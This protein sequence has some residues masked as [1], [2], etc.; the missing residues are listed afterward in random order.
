MK[1]TKLQPVTQI[2]RDLQPEDTV[3][4]LVALANKSGY[5]EKAD[6]HADF[7]RQL[8]VVADAFGR[9]L[10]EAECSVSFREAA[11]F[12][13][14]AREHR[15]PSTVADLRSYINRMTDDK[16][17]SSKSLRSISIADCRSLLFRKFGHSMHT[18]RK[19][20]S[21]LH[22]IFSY[23]MRQRWCEFNPAKAILRPPVT[24]HRIDI[25][26]IRQIR[27]MLECCREDKRLHPMEAPLRLMLWC[28]VRPTEMRRLCWND[29]DPTEAVVY[30]EPENSKTGGARAVPLRG[31][32]LRLL[33]THHTAE[34]KIAPSNWIR[35]WHALR[36]NAGFPLW[37]NDAL[38][39]TFASMHLKHFHN[40]PLLQEEMGH[41]NS[42][43]L[44]TR[45]LNL[46]N[47]RQ[48]TA[49]R[50]FN[51]DEWV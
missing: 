51:P 40:L 35:L 47:L 31:G 11:H 2:H 10:Q 18:Y 26:N 48:S 21:V 39:H 50:F 22:S 24:E 28:G 38:R 6:S 7:L 30:V 20:Q 32:A 37:Q 23:G 15:R 33:H 41:R 45:Y 25:L 4:L 44:Q 49:R 3:H 43:L 42:H 34:E 13:M 29:V 17:I 12:S 14:I 46:R 19:A 36:H 5:L 16:D 1:T 27:R 8:R 9:A